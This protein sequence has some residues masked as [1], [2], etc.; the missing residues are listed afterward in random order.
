[1]FENTAYFKFGRDLKAALNNN[2]NEWRT[3]KY[4]SP[5]QA[6]NKQVFVIFMSSFLPNYIRGY[7]FFLLTRI[8]SS[9]NLLKRIFSMRIQNPKLRS[10]A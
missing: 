1:M 2:V 9:Q 3:Q 8:R 10:K 7:S 6:V 5:C 4:V